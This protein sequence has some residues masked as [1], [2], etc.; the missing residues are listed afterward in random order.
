M[1][2]EILSGPVNLSGEN[3]TACHCN[4]ERRK[5]RIKD[6][7]APFISKKRHSDK[8]TIAGLSINPRPSVI[9]PAA[10][11]SQFTKVWLQY[12]LPLLNVP[13]PQP[14]SDE[15]SHIR[16]DLPPVSLPLWSLVKPCRAKA[17]PSPPSSHCTPGGALW[18]WVPY[19]S[20]TPGGWGPFLHHLCF[21]HRT[22][23]EAWH[24]AS[25]CSK[26]LLLNC[27]TEL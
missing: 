21:A 15:I 5:I 4:P 26:H 22:W 9:L 8:E 12:A 3:K 17:V 20:V 16:Q 10:R 6:E 2:T 18:F 24:L 14:P 13:S 11:P 23:Q 19:Q 1:I 7:R 27:S 25:Q